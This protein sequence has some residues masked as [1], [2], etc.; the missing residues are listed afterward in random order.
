[1]IEP[2]TGYVIL[3]A[4]AGALCLPTS[5]TGFT[6]FATTD[7]VCAAG[8]STSFFGKGFAA[9]GGVGVGVPS[10]GASTL[11]CFTWRFGGFCLATGI[12]KN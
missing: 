11:V 12:N 10:P 8:T 1:M 9:L 6:G 3:A 5:A 2:L 7:A 4:F